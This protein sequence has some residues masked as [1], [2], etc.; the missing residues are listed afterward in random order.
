MPFSS[1]ARSSCSAAVSCCPVQDGLG[2]LAADDDDTVVVGED[3]VGWI[4]RYLVAGGGGHRNAGTERVYL[5]PA[6]R[7]H[8]V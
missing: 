8:G 7:L 5:P 6:D 1:C 3:E 2:Q 4:D